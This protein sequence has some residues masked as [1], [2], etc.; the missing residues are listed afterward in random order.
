MKKEN[1]K[2]IDIFVNN[3]GVFF[4]K[5]IVRNR[6]VGGGQKQTFSSI[7]LH[8]LK[9]KIDDFILSITKKSRFQKAWIKGAYN[10][11]SYKLVNIL[12]HDP[13]TN[14]VTLRDSELKIKTIALSDYKYNTAKMFVSSRRNDKIIELLNA[15]QFDIDLLKKEKVELNETLISLTRSFFK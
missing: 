1:Y 15:K 7:N 11:G 10:D 4:T 3:K 2:G 6:K 13:N 9:S 5:V 8:K 14:T 12:L